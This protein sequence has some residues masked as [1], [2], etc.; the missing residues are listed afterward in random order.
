M[1]Q[2]LAGCPLNPSI[3]LYVQKTKFSDPLAHKRDHVSSSYQWIVS[4]S[5]LCF[6]L[7]PNLIEVVHKYAFLIPSPRP[8]LLAGL[9]LGNPEL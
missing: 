9:C 3:L 1:L 2:R 6:L 5:N 7:I 4:G 8:C